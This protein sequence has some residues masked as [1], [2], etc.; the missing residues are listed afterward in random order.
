LALDGVVV[1]A[2]LLL[3]AR[4]VGLAYT[5]QKHQ[6]QRVVSVTREAA[7]NGVAVEI[8]GTVRIAAKRGTIYVS[9]L[10]G[11]TE[12]RESYSFIIRVAPIKLAVSY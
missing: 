6:V 2:V 7:A 5:W 12:P 4:G 8:A 11:G 10:P 3:L 1:V 9:S